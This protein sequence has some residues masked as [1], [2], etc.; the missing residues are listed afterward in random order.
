[1]FTQFTNLQWVKPQANA[2]LNH[3]LECMTF[4]FICMTICNQK[5]YL[6]VPSSLRQSTGATYNDRTKQPRLAQD[7]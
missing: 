5:E 3:R 1:M 4:V 7:Y 6:Y 2:T